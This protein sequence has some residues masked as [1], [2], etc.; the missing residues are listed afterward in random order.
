[1]HLKTISFKGFK[2][3]AD[4]TDL[5]FEPPPDISA[6]VGPNG[7]GKSNIVDAVKFVLGDQNVKELRGS[8]LEELIFAGT[9]QRK[10]LSMAEVSFFIDNT[11]HCLNADYAEVEVKRRIFRSGESEFYINKVPC[12]LRDIREL[13]MD[14]GIGPNSYSII[15]QGQVDSILS[16]KPEERREIFEEAAGISKYKFR[17][18]SAERRL[19][20]TEQNMLRINDLKVEI[21]DQLGSLADQAEKAKQYTAIKETLKF[22][23]IALSKKQIRSIDEKLSNLRLKVGELRTNVSSS[24]AKVD[25]E[26]LARA[27]IKTKAKEISDEIDANR[28]L[29]D[30]IKTSKEENTRDLMLEDERIK[31][32]EDRLGRI[33]LEIARFTN[34]LEICTN[35]LDGKRQEVSVAAASVSAHEESLNGKLE[36]LSTKTRETLN[37]SDRIK[38]LRGLIFERE[39]ILSDE[40][41]KLYDLQINERFSRE[42]INRD[43]KSIKKISAEI[44]SVGEIISSAEHEKTG[45]ESEVVNAISAIDSVSSQI[46]SEQQK[47]Y[48]LDTEVSNL[49]LTLEREKSKLSLLKRMKEEFEGFYSGVREII[50]QKKDMPENWEKILGVVAD[51]IE[52]PEQYETAIETTLGGGIQNII[53]ED[54]LVARQAIEHLKSNNL[55]RATFLPLNF[56]ND[57][58]IVDLGLK[59]WS[60]MEGYLGV[61]VDLVKFDGR[62]SKIMNYLLGRSIVVDNSENAIKLANAIKADSGIF[63]HGIRIVTLSGEIIRPSGS[64]T[65]GSR[66]SHAPSLLGKDREITG[67][68]EEIAKLDGLLENL[69]KEHFSVSLSLKQSTEALGIHNNS[70]NSYSIKLGAIIQRI[71]ELTAKRKNLESDSELLASDIERRKMEI[72]EITKQ[73]EFLM[74]VAADLSEE[75]RVLNAELSGSQNN[76]VVIENEK[77]M[78]SNTVTEYRVA[79]VEASSKHREIKLQ[80][81]GEQ[82][83][84]ASITDEVSSRISEDQTVKNKIADTVN[85]IS[86]LRSLLPKMEEQ[87]SVIRAKTDDLKVLHL[88]AGEALDKL[89]NDMQGENLADRDLRDR[90]YREELNLSKLEIE[91]SSIEQRMKEE[92]LLTAENVLNFEGDVPS[93]AKAKD[94]VDSYKQD[95]RSLGPINLLAIDE[96]DKCR[97]RMDFIEK[98]YEDLIK[99]RENLSALISE[100]DGKAK[101]EFLATF[102]L[103]EKHFT[104]IFSTLFEDGEAKIVLEPDKDVLEAGIEI[105]SKPSGK[106]W[107]NLSLLSGGE[108]ALTAIALLFA[109]LRT[110]PSPFCILDEVDAALDEPNVDRF[111]KLLKKFGESTQIIIITHNKRTMSIADSIFGLTMEEPGISKIVSMKLARVI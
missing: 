76:L 19:I 103:V 17:K 16:A 6:I 88:E 4:K 24:K 10:P 1:M 110:H 8:T 74:S 50:K 73:G 44:S 28:I 46:T 53:T 32:L 33:T 58:V 25:S 64:I 72:N 85:N 20:A 21:R 59:K 67:I 7:C 70:K 63:A 68:S 86:Q 82:G 37:V 78:F 56:I 40:K 14:T 97:E 105:I 26:I 43:E 15:N 2:T 109:L 12:R 81:E 89:E 75:I 48:L 99:S 39:S 111:T 87:E 42:E 102:N 30:E 49:R 36:L 80:F 101:D 5:N 107:L 79:A 100:L 92:Y 29:L 106:K 69:I 104:D 55:G 65:G 3:F 41:N 31:N 34:E 23:E 77:N 98:Q 93:V 9:N 71:E 27:A 91:M 13:F 38:Q 90:L 18:R 108:R 66:S 54:D 83:R 35:V 60:G 45:I 84:F 61:A 62:I 52:T 96:F 47:Y 95:L 94:E 57:S 22:V 11:D 51:L